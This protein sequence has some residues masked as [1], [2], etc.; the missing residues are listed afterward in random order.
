MVIKEG[1]KHDGIYQQQNG[2]I[3][4]HMVI[5]CDQIAVHQAG[6]VICDHNHQQVRHEYPNAG[7]GVV[8]ISFDKFVEKLK[9]NMVYHLFYP[10][11]KRHRIVPPDIRLDILTIRQHIVKLA[12]DSHLDIKLRKKYKGDE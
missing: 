1:G 6:G 2:Q 10:P 3:V 7:K 9:K 11:I 4:G 12:Y 5:V 8:G